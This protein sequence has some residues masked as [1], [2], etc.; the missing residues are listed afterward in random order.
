MKGGEKLLFGLSALL[1]VAAV[2]MVALRP[3][4][5]DRPRP[6]KDY[7]EWSPESIQGYE[8][9]KRHGCNSC[10]RVMRVGEIGVAPV[11]DGE[12]TRRSRD[13]LQAY[14]ADPPSQVPGSAHDGSLGPD[15]RAFSGDERRLLLAFMTSLKSRPGSSNYPRPP[16]AAVQAR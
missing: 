6:A 16:A 11:L 12:G 4:A 7:A 13:W 3:S 8:L 9:Y 15:F 1:A 2:A 5:H 14:L 10:H